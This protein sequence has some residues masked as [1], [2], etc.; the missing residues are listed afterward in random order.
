MFQIQINK[1]DYT[2]YDIIP[3]TEIIINPFQEKLFHGD[4]FSLLNENIERKDSII[5]KQ[6]KIQGILILQNNKTYGSY[7]KRLLYKCVPN[8]INLPH[9]LIPYIQK[10]NFQKTFTNLFINFE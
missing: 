7:S 5:R 4:T 10:Y 1:R 6:K 8:E 2:S 9:F 3:S